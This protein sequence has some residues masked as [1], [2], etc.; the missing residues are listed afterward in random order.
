MERRTQVAVVV[1][2]IAVRMFRPA[3]ERAAMA[4]LVL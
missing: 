1:V 3:I 2:P 4:D